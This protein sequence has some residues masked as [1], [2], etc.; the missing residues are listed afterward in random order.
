MDK[1]TSISTAGPSG[2]TGNSTG[3]HQL[4]SR[5]VWAIP[6]AILIMTYRY[7]RLLGH[8]EL[9]LLGHQ[10]IRLPHLC[11]RTLVLIH[12]DRSWALDHFYGPRALI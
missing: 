11:E 10:D 1:S 12:L 4:D 5:V 6:Q 2:S 9:R 7:L 8:Q 3:F